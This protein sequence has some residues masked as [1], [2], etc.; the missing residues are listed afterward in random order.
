MYYYLR[1]VQYRK[2]T[3]VLGTKSAIL[4][5]YGQSVQQRISLS[6]GRS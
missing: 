6:H 4:T 2:S 5:T 1:M 3:R